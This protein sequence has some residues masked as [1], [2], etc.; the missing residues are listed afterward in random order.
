MTAAPDWLVARPIAHRGL[1]AASRGVPE[2]TLAAAE[3]AI[4]GG[5]AIEC[6]VQLSRDGEAMVFHDHTL[7]RLTTERG[8]VRERDAATLGRLDIGG[9]CERIPTLRAFLDRIAGRTPVILEIKSRFD[10]DERLAQRTA[11]ILAEGEAP[12]VVK[13]F[14]PAIVSLMRRI[15]P[16]LARGVVAQSRYEGG[17]WDRLDETRR[18]AMANLLHW[19]DTQPDF[20][21]WQHRDLPNA[22]TTLPRLLAGIPVMAWTIR[23]PDEAGIVRPHVDQIVF[24]GFVPA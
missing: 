14:D 13:S 21:S 1:H 6:D 18:R 10:G 19:G 7:D 17:E 12:V 2:N 5:F 22:A 11:A 8:P 23:S 9:T 16:K 4:A 15:A 3:A 24:E 20:L